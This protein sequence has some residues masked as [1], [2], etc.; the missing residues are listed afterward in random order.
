MGKID[1]YAIMS[2]R[3]GIHCKNKEQA[4]E[5]LR[6][7]KEQGYEWGDGQQY[8]PNFTHFNEELTSCYEFNNGEM[9]DGDQATISEIFNMAHIRTIEYEDLK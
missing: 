3:F 2:N 8:D 6:Q 7:A 4:M 9:Y 5:L 1:F